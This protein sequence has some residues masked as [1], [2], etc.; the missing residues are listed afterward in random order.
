MKSV[1]LALTVL[2]SSAAFADPPPP[3]RGPGPGWGPGWGHGP[4][5]F[6]CIASKGFRGRTFSVVD[7]SEWRARDRALIACRR[8]GWGPG[9]PG[10]GACNVRCRPISVLRD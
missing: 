2:L 10:F 4:R 6:E 7:R 8:S 9:R 5:A 3:P 1:L